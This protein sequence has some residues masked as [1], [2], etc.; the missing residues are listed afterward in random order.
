[1]CQD[2]LF[3]APIHRYVVSNVDEPGGI[4]QTY[5]CIDSGSFQTL[6]I[7]PCVRAAAIPV[8]MVMWQ[9]RLCGPLRATSQN[10]T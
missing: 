8:G 5:V 2:N 10:S 4:K 3:C 9:E 6:R 1:M 7:V